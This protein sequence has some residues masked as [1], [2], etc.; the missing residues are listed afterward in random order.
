MK[1]LASLLVAVVLAV[2]GV[3]CESSSSGS[4]GGKQYAC[5]MGCATSDKPGKCTKCGMEMKQK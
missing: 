5:S 1:W 2:S 4:G 3:G